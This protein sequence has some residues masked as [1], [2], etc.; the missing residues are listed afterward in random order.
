MVWFWRRLLQLSR[1][2]F[3]FCA[4][5]PSANEARN[6]CG[7]KKRG[8]HKREDQQQT[9][10]TR[11]IR[12]E[13]GLSEQRE[14][15]IAGQSKKKKNEKL[16]GYNG[17]QD[18]NSSSAHAFAYNKVIRLLDEC[19]CTCIHNKGPIQFILQV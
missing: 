18:A 4:F 7:A 1:F 2:Y 14:L 10:T 6:L 3:L 8:F 19:V 13:S 17:Y 5:E 9:M 12:P 16:N 11:Q 15:S